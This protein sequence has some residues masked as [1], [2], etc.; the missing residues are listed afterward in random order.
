MTTIPPAASPE[1]P[2]AG[3]GA[4]VLGL[5]IGDEAYA[6]D[7]GCVREIRAW[8]RPTRLAHAPACVLGVINLRGE[9]VPIVDSRPLFGAGSRADAPVV[10]M[11]GIG[12]R[13]LGLAV[14]A[15]TD[16]Q[17]LGDRLLQLL[18]AEALLVALDGGAAAPPR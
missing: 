16:V 9:I 14:D 3:P 11:L 6:I 2:A 18:D 7:V 10:V 5:R 15:V 17:P 8:E 12:R 1:D 13:T 4:E